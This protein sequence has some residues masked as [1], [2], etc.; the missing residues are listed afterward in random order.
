[1]QLKYILMSHK[2]V[3]TLKLLETAVFFYFFNNKLIIN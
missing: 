3:L 1:M 2:N